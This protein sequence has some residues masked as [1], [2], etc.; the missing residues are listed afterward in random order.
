MQLMPVR[1]IPA[2][3]RQGG[4]EG[5]RIRS[6]L[7]EQ[8]ELPGVWIV[9][10]ACPARR[11]VGRWMFQRPRFAIPGPGIANVI[12]ARGTTEEDELTGQR[13]VNEGCTSTGL[14]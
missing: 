7:V 5:R 12:P 14:G 8:Q 4:G 1:S 10:Q 3:H 2:P 6:L 11:R 9:G 13:L